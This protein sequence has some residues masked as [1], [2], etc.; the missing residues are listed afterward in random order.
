MEAVGAATHFDTAN[1]GTQEPVSINTR[2]VISEQLVHI[3]LQDERI[4]DVIGRIIRVVKT[5][6]PDAEFVSYIGTSPL[7]I[8]T[9]VYTP[10]YE[11]ENILNILDDRL[12]DL[13]VAAGLNVVIV[14]KK[15]VASAAA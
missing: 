15:K 6:Y 9:E 2:P 10:A 5:E 1:G 11:F 7:G 12:G 4:Q 14:P 8:Y 3:D 13:H